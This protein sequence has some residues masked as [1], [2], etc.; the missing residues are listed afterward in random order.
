ML[1]RSIEQLQRAIE[2]FERS[3]E[4]GAAH[5]DTGDC[6]SLLGRTYLTLEQLDMAKAHITK[7]FQI[8]PAGNSK[9]YL[10]LEIL[11]GDLDARE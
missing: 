7:A 10:D 9:D 6:H 8:L 4:H 3:P 11:A 1:D 5:S 2:L